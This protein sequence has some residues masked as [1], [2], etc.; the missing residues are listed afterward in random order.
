MSNLRII[1]LIV[2]ILGVYLTFRIYRGPSWRRLN[3]VLFGIFSVSLIAVSLNPNLLNILAQ[4][5]RLKQEQRGRILLLLIGSNIFLWF[6]FIYLKTKLDD[7]RYQ[8][9]VLVRNLGLEKAQPLLDKIKHKEIIVIIPAYNEAKNL[10]EV[11]PKIPKKLEDKRIGVIV[12]DDGSSDNTREI[13]E[14]FGFLVVKNKVNRGGGSAL[15]LGF[16]II[17]DVVPQIVVTM[18][19]DGQHDP[20]EIPQLV[21]PLLRKECDVVIGSRIIGRTESYSKV[22]ALGIRIFNFVI[23]IFTG[24]KITDCSSGFR[25][26]NYSALTLLDLK[27]E[28]YHTS[29]LII[30]AV[31]KG[32]KIKEVPITLYKRKYGKS[33]KGKDIIYGMNFART[34]IKAWWR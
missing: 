25:A 26:F 24:E 21:L 13:V 16:D 10:Q 32:L 6:M 27:E 4:M 11:L 28:Q 29:E 23:R 17:R 14:K 2:G 22:R 30:E 8:F 18:D 33:K 3:F 5:F 15:R 7:Y 34:I 12:I 19:A 20:K 31:K 9:D 1:G